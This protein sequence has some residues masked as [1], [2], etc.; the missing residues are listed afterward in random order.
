MERNQRDLQFAAARRMTARHTLVPAQLPIP[1]SRC[2]GETEQWSTNARL[3]SQKLWHDGIL[4][5]TRERYCWS[6]RGEAISAGQRSAGMRDRVV[7]SLR[8]RSGA[9]GAS[10]GSAAY[11]NTALWYKVAAVATPAGDGRP[12]ASLLA[13]PTFRLASA[14]SGHCCLVGRYTEGGRARRW[15][16]WRTVRT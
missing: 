16:E 11:G 15:Y 5:M 6:A 10:S 3:L 2:N 4:G 14:A 7:G 13:C 9:F 12:E 8:R 1:S